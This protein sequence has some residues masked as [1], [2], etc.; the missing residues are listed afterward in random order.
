LLGDGAAGAVAT[1]VSTE[2]AGASGSFSA[3][4]QTVNYTA[5]A[6]GGDLGNY[7]PGFGDIDGTNYYIGNDVSPE[8]YTYSF[9]QTITGLEIRINAMDPSETIDFTINGV[10]VDLN[11]LIASGAVTVVATGNGTINAN[12]D[13][14][15]DSNA[16]NG[17]STTLVFTMPISTIGLAHTG[18]S[19]GALVEL[20]VTEVTI[21]TG[22]DDTLGGGDGADTLYGGVGNDQLGGDAGND[23]LHGDAGNDTLFGWGDNDTLYGGDGN[24]MVDGDEG[25]D[26]LY[27]DAGSDTL[28]GDGGNDQLFGG[29]GADQLF[30]GAGNDTLTGGDGADYMSGGDDRDTFYADIGDTVDGSEGGDDYDTLDLTGYGGPVNVIYDPMNSENGTVEFLS[31]PGGSVV[32]TMTF[33]NIENVIIPCFTPGALIATKRG[34]VKVEA[35]VVGDSVLTRD[36]GY[37]NI[38]WIGRRDLSV[39]ELAAKPELRPVRIAKGALGQNL[40]EQD[41]I[42]SPQHRM[43]VSLT[44]AELLF[45]EHE[46]LVAASHML[47]QAGIQ[48][49]ETATGVSYIHLLFDEHEIIRADGAWSES[50]QPGELTLAGMEDAQRQEILA[51]FPELKLG[52]LFP[53]ARITLKKAEAQLLLSI[54]KPQF[55]PDQAPH[56]PFGGSWGVSN[57]ETNLGLVQFH[58]QCAGNFSVNQ[59]GEAFSCNA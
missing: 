54:Q 36:N 18:G 22:G 15:G 35:L 43:L 1:S 58:A 56:G 47:A 37:Q 40:P 12:G 55:G 19:A 25:D 31:G 5:T 38:R 21:V 44:R 48:I 26:S 6:T 3:G 9:D 2:L 7:S 27:G 8:S 34:A 29:D 59:T 16:P 50:Y 32:G 17:L 24:D 30:S 20:N 49:D 57:S 45:G 23:L 11:T 41:L 33:T 53:A 46:V 52:F 14:V 13:L 4:A 42:V 39:A 51:L 10:D 28:V